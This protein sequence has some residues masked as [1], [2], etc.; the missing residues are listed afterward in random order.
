M[1]H[2]DPT[3]LLH[4]SATR[5]EDSDDTA[6]RNLHMDMVHHGLGRPTQYHRRLMA[7]L[8]A[9]MATLWATSRPGLVRDCQRAEADCRAEIAGLPDLEP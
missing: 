1:D 6:W 4:P 7:D 2:A 5:P 8:Y 3:P 9:Q